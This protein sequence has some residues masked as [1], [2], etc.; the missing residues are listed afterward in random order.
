M[1]FKKYVDNLNALLNERPELAD[2][3]VV[4]SRDDEGNG[5]NLVHYKPSV[6]VYDEEGKEFTEENKNKVNAICVN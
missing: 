5:Y 4:T 6:G 2:F 3:D 1:K